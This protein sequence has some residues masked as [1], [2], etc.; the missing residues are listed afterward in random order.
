VRV[1]GIIPAR[2]GSKRLPG[3][4]VLPL[5]GTPLVARVIEAAQAASRIDRLIVTSD[6]EQVLQIAERYGASLRLVRPPQLA[7]DE[8]PAIDYV[9]HALGALEERGE[10]PFDAV[11]IL[12]PTSP[13]TL[14]AD[15]DATIRLLE[16][17]GADTAVSVV[18]LDHAVHPFKMKIMRGDRLLSFIE[19]ERGRMASYELPKIFVRNCSVY[20]TRRDI[21]L[22]K[23]QIIGD[24][25]RGYVMPQTRSLDINTEMDL[26]FAEFLLERSLTKES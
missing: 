18:E 2:K 21:V 1:L 24:D 15:I 16:T 10:A 11:C 25:C 23:K 14:P 3:K 19:E 22:D 7:A 8:S 4:N 5:G 17:S 12:Q 26:A 13:F 6:D 20:V 9:L